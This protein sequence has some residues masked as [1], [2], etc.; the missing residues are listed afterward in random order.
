[1]AYKTCVSIA[2]K[3]PKKIK[4]TLI[5]A[6]K[7]SDY[8]EIRFDFLSPNLVPDTLQLIKKDF[9]KCV[10][11]LRP[12]SEG[13]KFSGDEKNRV[14]IIKLISEYNPFLLDVE[15]NTLIKNKNL[16]NY[17]KN[18]ETDI[19]VSW[20]NFRQTPNIS[21]LKKKLLQMKKFSNNIKIVTM[22]KSIYDASTILSLYNNNDVKL[23]AFSMG[24]YGRIS[25]L[26]CLLLGSPYTYTSLGKPIAAGQFNVDEIKS[27]FMVRK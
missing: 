6:L 23:I 16:K 18:A 15:F 5:K 1:M 11:T 9:K 26:L 27:I 2:E 12:I 21:T 14:A 24:N 4:Q 22:A 17:L 10:A 8:A 19:L 3:T 25:R 13:G 7:K 20:H